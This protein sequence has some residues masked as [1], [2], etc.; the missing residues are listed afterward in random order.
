MINLT[1]YENNDGLEIYI[2]TNTGVAFTTQAGYCRMTGIAKLTISDRMN[3]P[4]DSEF[5]KEAQVVTPGGLQ[6]VRLLPL[7]T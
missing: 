2:D 1:R 3:K 7:L 4:S 5:I 6:G